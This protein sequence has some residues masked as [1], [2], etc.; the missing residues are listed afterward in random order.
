MITQNISGVVS[1]SIISTVGN[2]PLVRLDR[3]LTGNYFNLYGK[4]EAANPAGSIKDRTSL[5]I[6]QEALASGRIKKGDTVI[7]S[8]SGNMALGLA[9]TC[10]YYGLQL[11][12]VVDPKLNS[13]TEKIL[14]TYG[15]R[16]EHVTEPKEE[17][18]Y[19]AARLERVQHLLD[20]IPNS[21]WSNQ[22]G[23]PD[24][25][26]THHKT[27]TE[28]MDSLSGKLD[29]LFVATST[30][31]TLMGCADFIYENKLDTKIIAVDAVG[32][33]LFGGPPLKRLIP[34]H[35]A[36]VPSQFL[37]TSRIYDHVYVDDVDCARGCWS[38]LEKEAILCGGSSGGILSAVKKYSKNI[39]EGSN[40]A[41][42]LCDR[43]ERYLDT[44]YNPQWLLNELPE[45]KN[46]FIPIGGWQ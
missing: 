32:S 42:F 1:E 14:K 30:C 11:I 9:Q 37:D 23:N 34:G 3:I 38:L 36:G 8:S 17:G 22:Y 44:I 31:G 10:L 41:M 19:L 15:V 4:L 35:G 6:L 16:I 7:E 28:L 18:G 29:Y 12:V 25:P 39:E 2:T 20:S 33:V 46:A 13:H 21:F 43:G 27:M 24:N 45:C 26:K 5:Y 40:C